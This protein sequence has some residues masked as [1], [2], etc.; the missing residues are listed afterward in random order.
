MRRLQLFDPQFLLPSAGRGQLRL[1]I[2]QLFL[3]LGPG[4][5]ALLLLGNALPQA[6]GGTPADK[7]AVVAAAKKVRGLWGPLVVYAQGIFRQM[8]PAD[9]PPILAPGGD[10][11]MPWLP[12]AQQAAQVSAHRPT[13]WATGQAGDVFLCHPFLVHAASW[14]HR[15]RSAKMIAQPPVQL[16]ADEL[17]APG[18]RT[19][20]PTPVE[21][22]I[23]SGL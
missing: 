16:T 18:A 7:K 22:A 14:P 17:P 3:A 9:V 10:D 6:P 13:A 20:P 15:G 1:S 2:G 21:Q 19:G 23:Y 12:A 8:N 5:A 4:R 11:G